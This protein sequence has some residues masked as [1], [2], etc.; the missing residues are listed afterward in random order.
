MA[1]KA[2]L[3]SIDFSGEK[4]SASFTYYDDAVLDAQSQ[5]VIQWSQT[6]TFDPTWTAAQMQGAVIARGKELRTAK[7]RADVLRAQFPAQTTVISI[8]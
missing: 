7:D 2:R 3:E 6:F 1:W 5:P 8:P 4:V